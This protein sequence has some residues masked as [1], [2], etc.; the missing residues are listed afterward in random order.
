MAEETK[1]YDHDELATGS[2]AG[3]PLEHT[4]SAEKLTTTYNLPFKFNEKNGMMKVYKD[5]KWTRCCQ[6][7]PKTPHYPGL[8]GHKQ[9]VCS[10]HAKAVGTYEVLWPCRDCPVGNKLRANYPDENKNPKRL[11]A[12]HAKAVGTHEVRCP[13]RDCPPGKKIEASYPDEN[14][15]PSRLCAT[16]AKAVGTYEVLKPCRDC[17]VGNK[18]V[19]HYPDENNNPNRLCAMHAKAVGSYQV[20]NPCRDCPVGNK[21]EAHYPDENNN[22]KRLCATHAKAVGS[23]QVLDPCRDCPVGN[24]VVAHYPDENNK[25]NILCS[26]HAVLAGTHVENKSGASIIACECFDRWELLTGERI[27]HRVRYIACVGGSRTEGR[28][29]RGLIPGRRIQPDGYQE[30]TKTVWLFHGNYFHGFPPDHAKHETYLNNGKWGPDLYKDTM[31]QM[32]LYV[33][34]GY[35]VRYVWEHEYIETTRA[36]CPVSLRDVVHTFSK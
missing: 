13:C 26:R 24:K 33:K 16:H 7:C 4:I 11:C 19:A 34:H 22:P 21:L 36:R 6:Y 35:T 5:G 1:E 12:T 17:P 29:M 28:E 3:L 25:P 32:A 30:E 10:K 20:R 9:R 23:H 2:K 18:L 27:G 8:C 15:N 14:N 31:E